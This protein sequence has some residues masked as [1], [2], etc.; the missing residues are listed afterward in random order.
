MKKCEY[1][2]AEMPDD[3][4]LC[5]NCGKEAAPVTA[6]PSVPD[7]TPAE[8]APAPEA[9]DTQ[10]QEAPA[11]PSSPEEPTPEEPASEDST[12]EEPASEDPAPEATASEAPTPAEPAP[13]EATATQ[14]QEGAKATPGKIALAVAAVVVL[15]AVLI[16]LIAAGLNRGENDAEQTQPT[17][18]TA[19]PTASTEETVPATIPPDGNPDD[20]TCKGSYTASDA[21]AKSNKDTVIATIGDKELTNGALQVYYWMEVQGFLSNYGTY[22]PYFGM[23]YTKPLDTQ[24]SLEENGLT[25]QQYFLQCALDNWQ[26]IQALSDEAGKAKMEMDETDREYL[27]NL[28]KTLQTMADSYGMSVE[29]LLLNNFGPGAGMAEYTYFQDLYYRGFPYY[30]AET[31]KLVPTQKDLEEFY[32]AHR[33]NYENG[34]VTKDSMFVDVR[35][36]LI[37]VEGG[38]TDDEG[39]TTYSD[40]EWETCREKAQAVLDEWLDGDRTEDSFAALAMEKSEDPG[41]QNVGGLYQKVYEGQMVPAFN[42]WCFDDSRKNGDYALVQTDYGYHVMY[43]VSSQLQWEYYAQSDWVNEQTNQMI[44]SLVENY[45][46]DVSY[47]KIVLGNVNMGA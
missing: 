3:S 33:E 15:L 29:E 22:A 19:E 2:Q 1:C 25:W 41:S 35:H 7:P 37:R 14:I 26:R 6:D 20:V 31:A 32:D 16:A 10:P 38:T 11:Q 28:E 8:P 24:L 36:I 42:D 39:K 21:D 13:E 9:A 27:E 47:E 44:E 5:P 40:A 46:M 30:K 4:A 34:G 43:F 18:S 23:D 17:V 45:P 12:P